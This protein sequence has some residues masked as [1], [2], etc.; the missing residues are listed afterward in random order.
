MRLLQQCWVAPFLIDIYAVYIHWYSSKSPI[1]C[2]EKSHSTNLIL[3]S[4]GVDCCNY[5]AS[6]MHL[7]W[8]L[9]TNALKRVLC[10]YSCCSICPYCVRQ[11]L[12]SELSHL[13]WHLSS[14]M[15][16]NTSGASTPAVASTCPHCVGPLLGLEVSHLPWHLITNALEHIRCIHFCRSLSMATLS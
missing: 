12:F 1:L 16:L 10:I 15:L 14:P 5:C 7:L 3:I 11:S 4:T 13:L 8:H 6:C 9:F 2:Q